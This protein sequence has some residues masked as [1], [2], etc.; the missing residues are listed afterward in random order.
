MFYANSVLDAVSSDYELKLLLMGL[1]NPHEVA[2]IG[3]FLEK[4]Q[5]LLSFYNTDIFLKAMNFEQLW[6][7]N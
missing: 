4:K 7:L 2:T 1:K 5:K 3:C 6:H